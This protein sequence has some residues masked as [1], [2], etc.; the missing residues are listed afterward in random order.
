MT[1]LAM[2]TSSK[3]ASCALLRQGELRGEFFLNAGLTHSQTIMP[4]V[5]HLL[6]TAGAELG[7]VDLF[8]VSTGPG[9]FT[10][11][12]I[13]I[14]AVKGMAFACG[15]PCASV[16]TLEALAANLWGYPGYIL[17]AMDAR[18]SQVY[19][20]LFRCEDGPPRRLWEDC[21]LP[22]EELGERLFR[23]DGPVTLV[24]DGAELCRRSLGERF[25]RL[26]AAA[27]TLLHQRAGGVAM[28]AARLSQEE[29]TDAAE[30]SPAYLR[31]PQAERERMEREKG[32]QT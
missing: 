17:P 4:M 2:D 29:W 23:L 26:K 20:A 9:S 25:P 32:A 13:G 10:G 6:K 19:T 21:A 16:S 22:V 8:A 18:R 11:L 27:P 5:D 12:R 28:V 1:I 31:L 24:G 7:S 30:L 15:K 14:S 3:A